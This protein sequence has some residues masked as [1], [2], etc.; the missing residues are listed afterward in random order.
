LI[1]SFLSV[2]VAISQWAINIRQ[3]NGERPFRSALGCNFVPLAAVVFSQAQVE[4]MAKGAK[5]TRKAGRKTGGTRK[6][7]KAGSPWTKFVKKIYNEMKAKDPNVKLGAAMK[8]ASK[9][10]SEM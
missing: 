3:M 9:R 8:E 4:Q 2:V 1:I 5:N 6:G 7:K 10:K